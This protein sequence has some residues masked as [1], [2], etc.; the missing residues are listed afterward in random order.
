M[1]VQIQLADEMAN[2]LAAKARGQGKSV[3]ALIEQILADLVIRESA[4]DLDGFVEG[5]IG[6]SKA[7][8]KE[9]SP[10]LAQTLRVKGNV[11]FDEAAFRREHAEFEARVREVED[12]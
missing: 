1:V 2:A 6:K 7:L 8:R 11:P 12:E 4:D 5:L 9:P 3:D 10:S